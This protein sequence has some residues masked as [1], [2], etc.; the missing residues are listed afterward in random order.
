MK[1]MLMVVTIITI[2]AFPGPDKLTGRWESISKTGNVTGV[3][4]RAD[5]TFEGYVNKKPFVTGTYTYQDN[6][7][8]FV[9]NGCEGIRGTYKTNFYSNSDSMRFELVG[10]SCTERRN[11]MLNLVL[12]KVK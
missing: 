3:I 9:D 7:F 1:F 8:S 5:N 11:G 2:S 10:D 12:G 6:V 4:F